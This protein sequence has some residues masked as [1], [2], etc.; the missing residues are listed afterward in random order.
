[1]IVI[2]ALVLSLSIILTSVAAFAAGDHS[3]GPNGGIVEENGPLHVE[4]VKH[5]TD[6][7]IFIYDASMKSLSSTRATAKAT[8]LAGGKQDVV[9]LDS[10]Q[11]NGFVGKY[12]LAEGTRLAIEVT[13]PGKRPVLVRFTTK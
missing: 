4:L 9:N 8:V 2:R 10:V 3:K 6:I 1:M 13:L 12:T 5:A 11:P 7:K